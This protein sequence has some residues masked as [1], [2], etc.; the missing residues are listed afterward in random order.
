MINNIPKSSFYFVRHG[1]TDWNLK[2]VLMGRQDIS[3]N[4]NG[5]AQAEHAAYTLTYVEIS[6][7]F[8]STLNR[9]SK[10]ANIIA[11]ICELE[12]EKME[13]LCERG[14][15]L[16]E[17]KNKEE[18][19]TILSTSDINLPKDVEP[20]QDFER[21]VL[22]SLNKILSSNYTYPLIVSHG[23]VFVTLLKLLNCKQD[24]SCDN[25]RIFFFTPSVL[26]LDKWDVEPLET[27][28]QIF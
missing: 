3:L 8:S 28:K 6:K 21:R 25:G 16:L 12:V 7:I 23:G 19:L 14:F 11:D 18:S 27:L 26:W 15:G 2:H 20:Y 5:L 24:L 9:A 4:N 17:G 22:L 10:T 13:G 1:E